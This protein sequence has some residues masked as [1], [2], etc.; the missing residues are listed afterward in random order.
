MSA[1][2]DYLENAWLNTLKGTSF[3]V[4]TVFVKL[5]IGDPTETGAANPAVETTRKAVTLGT[6]ASGIVTND[7]DIDWTG[8]SNTETYSHIS[9]WDALSGGNA[10]MKGALTAPVPVT[11]GDNF[12][13]V[14]G[15]LALQLL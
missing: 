5:H 15:D 9:V 4:S 7:N 6:V 1:M 10:L 2:T 14:A 12:S 11:A 13:I 3:S 8:V